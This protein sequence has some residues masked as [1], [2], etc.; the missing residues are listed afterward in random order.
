MSS[1]VK[2]DALPRRDRLCRTC[3]AV[4]DMMQ[5]VPFRQETRED[6]ATEGPTS[7]E[8]M[9][10]V[11]HERAEVI[12]LRLTDASRTGC[13]DDRRTRRCRVAIKKKWYV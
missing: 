1:C 7:R 13:A 8:I 4:L 10:T 11:G 5:D 6:K 2:H 12:G 3:A 9:T